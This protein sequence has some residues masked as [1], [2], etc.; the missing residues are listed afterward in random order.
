[1]QRGRFED[2]TLE[3]AA[4]IAA[5]GA[6]LMIIRGMGSRIDLVF[7]V[8]AAAAYGSTW[9]VVDGYMA[10]DAELRSL[11]LSLGDAG[12]EA[13]LLE[14]HSVEEGL[15]R[16]QLLDNLGSGVVPGTLLSAAPDALRGFPS[17]LLSS[18]VDRV[19]ELTASGA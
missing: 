15:R 7:G 14:V 11:A 19:V 9:A 10:S 1:T 4:R 16:L 8:A 6:E 13:V 2:E 12:A 18:W 3:H 5:G 17:P